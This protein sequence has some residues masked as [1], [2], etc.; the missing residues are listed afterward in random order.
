MPDE[1]KID[2][3]KPQAPSI[4]GVSHSEEKPEPEPPLPPEFPEAPKK[5]SAPPYLWTALAGLAA[6]FTVAGLLY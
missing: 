1:K 5:E 2:P 4:P 6:L 3:F